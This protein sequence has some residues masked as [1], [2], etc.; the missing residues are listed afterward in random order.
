MPTKNEDVKMTDA[1]IELNED[2]DVTD[3]ECPEIWESIDYILERINELD[4]RLEF[5]EQNAKLKKGTKEKKE[6]SKK[7]KIAI[8]AGIAVAVAGAGVGTFFGVKKYKAKKDD[9]ALIE[10]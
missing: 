4:E 6:L 9:A 3:C 7:Q 8:G 10:E 5:L 1:E 2:C